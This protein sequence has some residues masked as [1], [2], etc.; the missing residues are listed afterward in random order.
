M[1][2]NRDRYRAFA[3]M[4]VPDYQDAT[5]IWS[6]L[7]FAILSAN[8]PFEDSTKALG[9]A[10]EHRIDGLTWHGG[11]ARYAGMTPAKV[12]YVNAL[13]RDLTIRDY[14]RQSG[15]E[16][17]GYRTRLWET[18]QGLGLTK[19]S[20][21]ACLLYPTTADVACIDTHIQKVYLGLSGFH[22]LGHKRYCAIEAE[23][24]ELADLA[25]VHTFLAQWLLWD[26][27]RGSVSNH[28]IFPGAHKL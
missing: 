12:G 18:V 13:P 3:Q 6:R 20:F 26:Y 9:Y 21:A 7:V 4:I 14:L 16:W 15:E 23:I 8:A 10:L 19:A 5:A 2:E 25:G 1:I 17:D 22:T 11:L 27:T 24:R 28:A